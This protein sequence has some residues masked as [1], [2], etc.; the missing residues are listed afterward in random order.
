MSTHK[1]ALSYLE[2]HSF[3]DFRKFSQ[4]TFYYPI[5]ANIAF[6]VKI[7]FHQNATYHIGS[8]VGQPLSSTASLRGLR[9]NQD[10]ILSY[11]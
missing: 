7:C 3:N 1:R 9:K 8:P 10:A 11:G 4:F 2:V 5:F 6:G